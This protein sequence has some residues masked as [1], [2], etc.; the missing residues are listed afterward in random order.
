MTSDREVR[1]VLASATMASPSPDP[2]NRTIPT[3]VIDEL[4]RILGEAL[5]QQYRRDSELM[6]NSP[7]GPDHRD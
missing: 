5:V 4:A 6:V 7:G 2:R 3:P 1:E